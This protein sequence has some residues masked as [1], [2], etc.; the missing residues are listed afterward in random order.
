MRGFY[1]FFGRRKFDENRGRSIKKHYDDNVII[2]H[3]R[4]TICLTSVKFLKIST[5]PSGEQLLLLLLLLLLFVY[6]NNTVDAV[7]RAAI[8]ISRVAPQDV[9][10]ADSDQGRRTPSAVHTL[11]SLCLTR[12]L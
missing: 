11:L 12:S 6:Y 2:A 8:M 5:S 4:Q 3:I 10:V 1:I 9:R 7:K